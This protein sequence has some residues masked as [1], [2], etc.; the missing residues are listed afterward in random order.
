M[1]WWSKYVG[2]PFAE[3]HC[4]EL[5]RR[6]Y[7]DRLGVALPDYGEVDARDLVRVAREIEQGQAGEHWQPVQNPQDMDVALMRGRAR[8]WHVGVMVGQRHVLHTE[9]A[10]DAVLVPLAHPL[11]KGR[12]TGFRRYV[13]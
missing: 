9:A 3:A 5:V 12:I 6:V 1:T 11:V 7:Q 2:T 4:W 10:T 8:V 13:P